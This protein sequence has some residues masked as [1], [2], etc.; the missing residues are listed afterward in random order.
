[1]GISHGVSPSHAS[2][3]YSIGMKG[4]KKEDYEIIQQDDIAHIVAIKGLVFMS[5]F[6]PNEFCGYKDVTGVDI[7]VLIMIDEKGDIIIC[8]PDLG[9]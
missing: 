2:Y 7:P 4:A 3:E 1:C 6:K 5:I 8:N 9:L